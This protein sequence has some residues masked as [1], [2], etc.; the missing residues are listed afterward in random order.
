LTHVVIAVPLVAAA[1]FGMTG[2]AVTRRLPP[3]QATWLVS[4]G[5][6]LA[7]LSSVVVLAL[8]GGVLVGQDSEVA[9]AGH[10]S[11]AALRA[12]AP[13]DRDVAAGALV[14]AVVL[15]ALAGVAAYRH[16]AALRSA[17]RNARGLP[18]AAGELV[19]VPGAGAAAY[20]LPGRPG[21]I[22]V[23]DSLLAALPAGE[24]RAVMEH[25]RSHLTHGHHW[26]LAAVALAAA[27]NPM[28]I[29]L[30][31]AGRRAVERWAD[32]DAAAAVGDRQIVARAL[33]RA[34]L[35]GSN[36]ASGALAAAS[37]AVPE[38][39]AALRCEPPQPRRVLLT[40]AALLLMIGVIAALLATTQVEDLFELA[41]R[42]AG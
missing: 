41:R 29:P 25:E 2:P 28:L 15:V 26:H 32:E 17:Y 3:G 39:V 24:R 13:V 31:S 35:L 8:L 18:P 22:V 21:R 23:G 5:A 42:A 19:V 14:A 11:V 9:E 1:C 37:P 34:A 20:A 33:A 10:W 4:V 12:H 7:A 36:A 40:L 6:A 27:L 30:R 38:R 16:G